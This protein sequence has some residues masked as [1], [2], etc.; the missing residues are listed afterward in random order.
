MMLSPVRIGVLG[1]GYFGTLHAL[2]VNSLSEAQLCAVVDSS[3]TALAKLPTSLAQIPHYSD[4]KTAIHNT[5]VEAWIVASSTA[6][7]QS[8][9]S[10]PK[11]EHPFIKDT[12]RHR[13][14]F[15]LASSVLCSEVI[16]KSSDDS[17][18]HRNWNESA[19]VFLS[20]HIFSIP[21]PGFEV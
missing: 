7:H 4:L 5:D 3:A 10:C 1:A 11:K 20:N 13:F 16:R 6:S 19:D 8:I 9:S 12:K 21:K 15:S 14:G 18:L 2:T 17:F